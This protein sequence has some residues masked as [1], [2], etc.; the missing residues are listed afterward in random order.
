[1]PKTIETTE[2]PATAAGASPTEPSASERLALAERIVKQNVY[3]SMG[4]GAVPAPVVDLVGVGGFQLRMLKQ[5]SDLY[6]VRFSEHL[7]KNIIAALVGSIGARALT[8]ATVG[9]LIKTLPFA[10]AL[11]GGV[12][13]MP[14]IAGAS[15]YAVGRVFVRHFE[16]GGT[17]ED[18]NLSRARAYFGSQYREGRRMAAE[19]APAS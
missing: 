6:G 7:A 1:M 3:W 15:T 8:V 11:I 16:L 2:P 19:P 17:F 14:L 4:C 5:L 13:A 18:L 9:S 10:G 12:L